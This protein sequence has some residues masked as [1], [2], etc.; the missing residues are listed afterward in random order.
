MIVV[1]QV[2]KQPFQI[3]EF[4]YYVYLRSSS[5]E[6]SVTDDILSARLECGPETSITDEDIPLAPPVAE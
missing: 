5:A 1:L 6:N 3:K 4:R 2:A